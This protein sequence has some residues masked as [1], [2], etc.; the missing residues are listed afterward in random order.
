MPFTI[1]PPLLDPM[2]FVGL[3]SVAWR[4]GRRLYQYARREGTP[5]P[6]VNGEYWLLDTAIAG[7]SAGPLTLMDVGAHHGEWT[8]E[9]RECLARHHR[10]G[11]T[12]SFE[13]TPST[14]EHLTRR[15][16]GDASIRIVPRALSEHPGQ[17]TFHV[18]ADMN[19]TNSLVPG[20]A[21][22]PI[23][24]DV[25][26]VDQFLADQGIERVTLLKTDTEGNDL[27]VLRGGARSLAE[28]RIDAWQFEYN[29]RWIHARAFLRDVF[30]LIAGKPYVIGKVFQNGIE[31]YDAWHPE[32]ERYF[33]TNFVLIR[34]GTGLE[35]I[36][37]ASRFG[38]SNTPVPQPRR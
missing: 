37:A 23:Q 4:V 12:H 21:S 8:S 5:H 36:A 27:A 18:V 25:T 32:L 31:L 28:G 10:A 6:R 33:E 14:F 11:T 19:G 35:N 7:A 30:E 20:L 9:A 15:F 16:S 3:R 17:L 26:T 1:K 13:P 24:V 22:H 38:A 2:T 29:H 34:K